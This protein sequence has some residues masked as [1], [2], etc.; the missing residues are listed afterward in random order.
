MIAAALISVIFVLLLAGKAGA[1]VVYFDD[2]PLPEDV[3]TY[4]Y[5]RC[6]ETGIS[7][8]FMIALIE[9]ES[10]FCA[11]V[12]SPTGD[13]GLCQINRSANE[14]LIHELGVT[15]LFDEFQN[16]DCAMAILEELFEKYKEPELVLMCYNMGED[17]A[18]R[19]WNMGRWESKYS[20]SVMRK[21]W[22]SK[23]NE[24]LHRFYTV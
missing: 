18:R 4:I 11:D 23:Y 19:C 22:R 14:E 6:Q 1:T 21:V 15:S 9:Q 12:V 17:G 3:Q 13:F 2:I 16:I 5:N 7:F 24:H 10:E 8:E 20:V